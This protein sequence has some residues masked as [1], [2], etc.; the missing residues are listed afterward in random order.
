MYTRCQNINV[1]CIGLPAYQHGNVIILL[2]SLLA[3]FSTQKSVPC[4]SIIGK[5]VE[6]GE[7]DVTSRR[8]RGEGR[9]VIGMTVLREML[10][11]EWGVVGGG[12]GCQ[13]VG[14]GVG[15]LGGGGLRGSGGR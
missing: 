12:K 10:F 13:W 15:L 11:G 1:Q 3:K 5:E 7:R 9:E 4:H 6:N 8:G 2:L 14:G